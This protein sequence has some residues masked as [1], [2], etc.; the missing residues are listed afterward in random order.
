MGAKALSDPGKILP[1]ATL[2]L[3]GAPVTPEPF[4][5]PSSTA[6]HVWGSRYKCQN[7]PLLG[8]LG[9]NVIPLFVGN[10]KAT[11]EIYI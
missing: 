9:S 3:L 4:L 7:G 8:S 10:N 2:A 11:E 1:Q 5:K 6:R